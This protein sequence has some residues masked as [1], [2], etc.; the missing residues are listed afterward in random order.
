MKKNPK[1]LRLSRETIQGL[2]LGS[3]SGGTGAGTLMNTQCDE[4]NTRPSICI[5]IA[6]SPTQSCL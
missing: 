3:V 4:C 1:R 6:C 5:F 2:E